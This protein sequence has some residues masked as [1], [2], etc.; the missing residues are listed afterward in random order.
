MSEASHKGVI[1]WFARNPVAAN[2]LMLFIFIVGGNAAYN[3]QRA[4]NP[5]IV[6]DVITIN[7]AYPGAA[8]LEVEQGLVLKIEEAIKGWE[9]WRWHVVC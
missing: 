5:E 1:A 7:M 4:L 2:L 9:L 3:I 8:P 6:V